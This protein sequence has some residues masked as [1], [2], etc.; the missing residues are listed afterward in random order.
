MNNVSTIDSS[1][2]N[3]DLTS[4]N[5]KIVKL[6]EM[7]T[8]ISNI[9]SQLPSILEDFKN[10]YIQVNENPGNNET[11]QIFENSKNQLQGLNSRLFS[12][13]NYLRQQILEFNGKLMEIDKKI[14]EERIQNKILKKK[15]HSLDTK[16]DG[17]IEIVYEYRDNYYKGYLSNFN[18]LIGLVAAILITSKV[19]TSAVTQ[20]P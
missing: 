17:S 12:L 11:V 3:D 15:F 8:Q 19:T 4:L 13:D 14:I 18:M 6:E 10:N 1:S 5:Q 7:K 20:T 9:Q 2:T 16:E